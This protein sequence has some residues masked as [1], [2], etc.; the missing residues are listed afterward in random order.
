MHK[1][2]RIR[3][4]RA[5]LAFHQL[6]MKDLARRT[7]IDYEVLKNGIRATSLGEER[8]NMVRAELDLM[9]QERTAQTT[10]AA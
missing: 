3:Q 10:P 9:I 2:T 7:G 1:T 4:L 6:K 5:D 8:L